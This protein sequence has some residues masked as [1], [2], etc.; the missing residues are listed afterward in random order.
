[1]LHFKEEDIYIENKNQIMGN[2]D[3]LT[4]NENEEIFVNTMMI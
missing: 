3:K 1:M 4:M 2:E